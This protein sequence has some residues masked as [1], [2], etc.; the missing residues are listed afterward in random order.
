MTPVSISAIETPLPVEYCHALVML[1]IPKP[2]AGTEMSGRLAA[3]V[4]AHSLL[5]RIGCS[6]VGGPSGGTSAG[7]T[8]GGVMADAAVLLVEA[9]VV[10]GGGGGGKQIR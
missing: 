2:A 5:C 6:G 10:G 9:V 7:S 3:I 8:D 4:S 1:S